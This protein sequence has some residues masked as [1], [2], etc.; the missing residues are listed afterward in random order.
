MKV[1]CEAASFSETPHFIT[2]FEGA[3]DGICGLLQTASSTPTAASKLA[4]LRQTIVA[5]LF[6]KVDANNA[7]FVGISHGG[8]QAAEAPTCLAMEAATFAECHLHSL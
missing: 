4:G 3:A 5:R 7:L 6:R 1:A 8:R 2:K